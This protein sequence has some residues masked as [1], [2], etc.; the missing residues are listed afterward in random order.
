VDSIRRKLSADSRRI[1]RRFSA[2]PLE[3]NLRTEEELSGAIALSAFWP[4]LN[5]LMNLNL[6]QSVKNGYA[7]T[8][9]GYDALESLS[10]ERTDLPWSR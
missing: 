1:L 7:L 4:A 5:T 9:K 2:D 3:R 8:T 6:V 10:G